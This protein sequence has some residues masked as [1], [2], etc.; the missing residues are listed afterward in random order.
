MSNQALDHGRLEVRITR[1][2]EPF[3]GIA[4]Q[5]HEEISSR[6]FFLFCLTV[7]VV[8]N[9]PGTTDGGFHPFPHHQVL[10]PGTMACDAACIVHVQVLSHIIPQSLETDQTR[11]K[12]VENRRRNAKITISLLLVIPGLRTTITDQPGDSRVY[13]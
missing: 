1:Y 4:P 13:T 8:V 10:E 11:S 9:E 2:L 6:R 5:S 12:P 3:Q 7:G